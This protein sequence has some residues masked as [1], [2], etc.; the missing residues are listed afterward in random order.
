[1]KL[2]CS[3]LD[4]SQNFD[5]VEQY[6]TEFCLRID[7]CLVE[8]KQ[9]PD[10]TTFYVVN[11]LLNSYNNDHFYEPWAWT[12]K[13]LKDSVKPRPRKTWTL[14]EML[15]SLKNSNSYFLLSSLGKSKTM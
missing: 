6:G 15:D 7:G 12:L 1:M 13:I 10:L 8:I 11:E 9:N 3:N 14:Q 5:E 2:K 4:L